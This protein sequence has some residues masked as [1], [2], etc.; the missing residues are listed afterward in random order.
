MMNLVLNQQEW[1]TSTVG[2]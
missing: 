1:N 2:G